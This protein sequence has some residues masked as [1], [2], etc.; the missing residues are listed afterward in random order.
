[1]KILNLEDFLK[2]PLG[3][4]YCNF[5][6]CCYNG[7]L[8]IKWEW[9]NTSKNDY[10]SWWELQFLPWFESE[11]SEEKYG[12]EENSME[13][14]LSRASDYHYDKDILFCVFNKNEIGGMIER[15]QEAL[16]KLE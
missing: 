9:L 15:L 11:M 4:V 2:E 6:P 3:T 10:K 7:D 14:S 1:M 13:W 12:E 8:N 5:I 16:H